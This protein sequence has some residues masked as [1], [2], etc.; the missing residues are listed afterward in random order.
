MKTTKALIVLAILA[1]GVAGLLPS[2]AG[3][4]ENVPQRGLVQRVEELEGQVSALTARVEAL[5]GVACMCRCDVLHLNPL[6]DFP[7]NPSEGDLCVVGESGDRH[8]YC[9]LDGDWQLL[10]YLSQPPPQ[11]PPP[12]EW[13]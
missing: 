8:I 10:D 11:E 6:A 3:A 7:S 5:E 1:L 4:P 12:P 2:L 9:Y 13:P